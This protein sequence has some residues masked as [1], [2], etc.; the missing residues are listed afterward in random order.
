MM[1]STIGRVTRIIE[2]LAQIGNLRRLGDD[3]VREAARMILER[4]ASRLSDASADSSTGTDL[5]AT[6]DSSAEALVPMPTE[7]KE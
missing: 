6:S 7:V 3:E 2:P 5:S 1:E 4:R